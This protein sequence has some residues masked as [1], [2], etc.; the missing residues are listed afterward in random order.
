MNR[1][2]TLVALLGMFLLLGIFFF[3][4]SAYEI[5]NS[6][7]TGTSIVALGDSLVEGV[8][9]TPGNDF[10]S[11]LSTRIGEPIVNL[12]V[13]GNTSKDA[14]ARIDDV[15]AEDPRVVLILV[16]GNDYL[17]RVPREEVFENIRTLITQIQEYGSAVILL[18]VRG[19][20]LRDN[21]DADFEALARELGCG[22]VPNVLDGL[23]G[24]SELM[25]DAIHPNDEGYKL[26]ADK[27]EPVVRGVLYGK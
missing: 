19:G 11:L 12:G 26:I 21:F 14:L 22:F 2:Y 17:R 16:G 8:G 5:R 1:K 24:N 27:V 13:R 25:Y 23:L 15:L 18:G 9:A 6:D 20:I 3:R 10:V 4:D 7:S